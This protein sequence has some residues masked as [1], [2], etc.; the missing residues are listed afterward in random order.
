MTNRST[1]KALNF[2]ADIGNS[3]LKWSWCSTDMEW[4]P[5]SSAYVPPLTCDFLD[6]IWGEQPTP[7]FVMVSNVAGADARQTLHQWVRESWGINAYFAHYEEGIGKALNGYENKAQLGVDRWLAL[8]AAREKYD[9]AL[10]V[11][12]CGTAITVDWLSADNQHGG[13]LIVPGRALLARAARQIPAL[14]PSA[15]ETAVDDWTWETTMARNTATALRNGINSAVIGAISDVISQTLEFYGADV[16][17]VWTGG[18]APPSA[19]WPNVTI[20]HEPDLV[21]HGLACYARKR[22]PS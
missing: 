18:D 14:Q 3:R 19:H 17:F 5:A 22:T 21:L 12:D 2:Y 11:I 20:H 15:D 9:D 6:R 4:Q 1:P 7:N 13:G 16:R 10:C 8:L